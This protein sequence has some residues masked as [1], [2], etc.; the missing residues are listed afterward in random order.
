MQPANRT[1]VRKA[2]TNKSPSLLM[3]CLPRQTRARAARP[4][5]WSTTKHE[6]S[7]ESRTPQGSAT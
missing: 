6:V 4:E 7:S 3:T 1:K 5:P 2:S